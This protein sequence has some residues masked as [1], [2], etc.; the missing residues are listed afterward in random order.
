MTEYLWQISGEG[1]R[2]CSHGQSPA[3][4]EADTGRKAVPHSRSELLCVMKAKYHCN[5]RVK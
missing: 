3:P 4:G 2:L 1:V 5:F